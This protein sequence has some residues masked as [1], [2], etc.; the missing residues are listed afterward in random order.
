[1]ARPAKSLYARVLDNSFRS[2][3]YGRLLER[4]PLPRRSPFRDERRRE[5]WQEL[6]A[7]QRRC[8][9]EPEYLKAHA[10]DFSRIVRCLHGSVRPRW[11][12]ERRERRRREIDAVLAAMPVPA[13]ESGA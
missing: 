4:E 13:D 10:R 1:M 6:R 5:L 12:L 7:I 3:R 9:A 2:D 11:Y 8:Q